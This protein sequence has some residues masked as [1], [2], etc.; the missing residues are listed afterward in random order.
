MNP[1]TLYLVPAI[2]IATACLLA[3]CGNK[4]EKEGQKNEA[5]EQA[6]AGERRPPEFVYDDLGNIIQRKDFTYDT[7]GN[8]RSKNQYDYKFDDRNNRIQKKFHSRGTSRENVLFTPSP[9]SNTTNS[10]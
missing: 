7:D 10:T 8:V 9:V 2:L 1:R 4:K 6:K 3:S 5:T